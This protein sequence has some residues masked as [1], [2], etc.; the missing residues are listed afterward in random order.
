MFAPWILVAVAGIESGSLAR[1]DKALA[2]LRQYFYS[3][4]GFW[5]SADS[6]LRWN[7]WNALGGLPSEDAKLEF[8]SKLAEFP[9]PNGRLVATDSRATVD[10]SSW[11]GTLIS[12][13]AV[14]P[15]AVSSTWN[16]VS[17]T[18]NGMN[19]MIGCTAGKRQA[20]RKDAYGDMRGDMRGES[21]PSVSIGHVLTTD[22]ACCACLAVAVAAA[23]GE[24]VRESLLLLSSAPSP[25]ETSTLIVC[26]PLAYVPPPLALDGG[27]P[28]ESEG[29]PSLGGRSLPPM[30][31]PSPLVA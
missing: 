1:A 24:A 13:F 29:L 15:G 18:W 23:A 10:S 7:M 8:V 2:G 14:I 27:R 6:K 30:P 19:E 31:P 4:P 11:M 5:R 28:A 20:T 22:D 17:T 21:I 25:S 12:P 26:S 3:K 16:G 9:P